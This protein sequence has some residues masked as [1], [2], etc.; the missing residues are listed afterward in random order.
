VEVL[1]PGSA[2]AI[3]SLDPRC[4]TTAG[5]L[6]VT[7]RGHG[8]KASSAVTFGSVPSSHVR[9]V[10]EETVIVLAPAGMPGTI[11]IA[12]T[13]GDGSTTTATDSF[14]YVSPLDP[15]GCSETRSRAG[16]K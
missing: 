4:S 16:R 12:V 13:N 3:G 2:P 14:R 6:D 10:D 5:G 1:A 7:L 15:D 9:F 11:A 8:F